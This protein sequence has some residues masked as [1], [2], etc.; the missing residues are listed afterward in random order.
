MYYL[1]LVL[2]VILWNIYLKI[3]L[4]GFLGKIFGDAMIVENKTLEE[5][6]ELRRLGQNFMQNIIFDSI[7]VPVITYIVFL[8]IF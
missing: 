5:C 4:Y 7:I 2:Y 6:Y 1:F 3:Y 8:S